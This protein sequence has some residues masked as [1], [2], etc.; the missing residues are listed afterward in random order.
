V[1]AVQYHNLLIT[2]KGKGKKMQI[3][4]Q[5]KRKNVD[6]DFNSS[7]PMDLNLVNNL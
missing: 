2:S 1:F 6:A 4:D 3:L 7:M 5:R